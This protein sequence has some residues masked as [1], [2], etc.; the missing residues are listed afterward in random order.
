MRTP[1]DS[2]IRVLR[3]TILSKGVS[4]ISLKRDSWC[5]NGYVEFKNQVFEILVGLG[6]NKYYYAKIC[7]KPSEY[8]NCDYILYNPYGHF[9]FSRDMRELAE[10]LLLKLERLAKTETR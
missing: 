2:D 7:W 6:D 4:K 5:Y 10:K 8:L 1:S 9:V 3:E